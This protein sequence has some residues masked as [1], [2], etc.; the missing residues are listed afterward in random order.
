MWNISQRE[1]GDSGLPA[2]DFVYELF[3]G[4]GEGN[5]DYVKGYRHFILNNEWDGE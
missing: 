4:G 3:F 5:A 1:I 2:L